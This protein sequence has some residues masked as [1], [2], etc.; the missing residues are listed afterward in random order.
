MRLR[1]LDHDDH[2]RTAFQ[3]AMAKVA[4]VGQNPDNLVD[5][6][7]VIPVP[8]ARNATTRYPA[9]FGPRDA[10]HSVRVQAN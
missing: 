1:D 6:S 8:P 10:E 9:G 2:L 4:I 5:C 3:Q 7:V